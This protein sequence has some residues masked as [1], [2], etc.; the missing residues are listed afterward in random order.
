MVKPEGHVA[1]YPYSKPKTAS[2]DNRESYIS[3][4]VL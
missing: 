1:E 4:L 2:S 3:N